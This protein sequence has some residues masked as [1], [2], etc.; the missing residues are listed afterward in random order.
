MILATARPTAVVTLPSQHDTVVLAMD[1]SRSMLAEDVKPTRIVAA[2]EA[3]RAFVAAQPRDTR[4]AIVTF[5]ATAS[6]VQPPTQNREDLLAAID[7]FQLQRGTAVGS[8]IVVSLA[9]LFPDAKIDLNSLGGNSG[10]RSAAASLDAPRA[11]AGATP[12][13]K[14]V[15]P[16]SYPS[17]VII[18]LTDGQTTTGPDPLEAARLAADRGVRVFT[19]GIGTV[20]GEILRSEGWSMRV[21][22]DEA[23]LKAIADTTRGEYYYAGNAPDLKKV[24]QTLNTK[25]VMETRET[26]VGALFSAA[27]ALFAL[28]AAGLSVLWFHR[29]F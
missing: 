25:L 22:L 2:Q 18:L 6:L 26:E 27:A 7:R 17:G 16:G 28:A 20:D 10:R 1:V 5:A 21:R 13:F 8:G 14:P 29:I 4:V 11:E 3:A 23:S 19:V 12:D 9:T 24:Y 15:P